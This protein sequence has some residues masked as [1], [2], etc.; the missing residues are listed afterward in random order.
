[1]ET[2]SVV[3]APRPVAVGGARANK[4]AHP[5]RVDPF[6]VPTRTDWPQGAFLRW[7]DELKESLGLPSDL[8]LA[9]HLGIGHTLISGWR[10]GRQRPSQGTLTTIA[11][12]TGDDPRRLWVLAGIATPQEVGLAGAKPPEPLPQEIN[13]LIALYRRSDKTTRTVLLGQVAFLVDAIGGRQ[14]V[15]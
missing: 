1:M 7:L 3:L 14:R 15:R 9:Q 11:A 4:T 5:Y 10:N 6:R 12:A 2:C 8:Q 13:D